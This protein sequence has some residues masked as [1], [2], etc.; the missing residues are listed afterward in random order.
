MEGIPRPDQEKDEPGTPGATSCAPA[1]KQITSLQP[2]WH[3]IRATVV[4]GALVLVTPARPATSPCSFLA[5]LAT[6]FAAIMARLVFPDL[7][8]VVFSPDTNPNTSERLDRRNRELFLAYPAIESV[9]TD[10]H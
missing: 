4:R 6:A 2:S 8:Y 3:L 5:L 10:F 9:P 7:L 1:S